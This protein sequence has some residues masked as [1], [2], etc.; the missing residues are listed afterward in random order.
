MTTSAYLLPRRASFEPGATIEID[1]RGRTAAGEVVVRRLGDPIARLAHDGGPTIRLERLPEGRYGVELHDR[2]GIARTAVEVTATPRS[3]LRYGFAVD[4]SPERDAQG[5]SDLVRRLHLTGVLFY[6]WA[7]RHADLLGGGDRYLD[8]LAQPV[9]LST[10]RRL[11]D[12]VHAAG[13]SAIGYA[14]V[15]AVGPEEWSKWKHDA[16]LRADGEPFALGDFLFLVDPASPD[17]LEHFQL[18]LRAATDALG[19]AGFHLD[20]F[21]YPKIARRADGAV[22]RMTESFTRLIRGVRGALPHGHLVFNNVNDFP[23]WTTASAPQDAVYIEPW[24]PTDTLGALAARASRAREVAN[25]KPVVFAAYQQVYDDAPVDAADRA[26]ALTMA[27]LF[28]HGAT[29]LLAGEGDR[30]LVDP[31][32]VRNHVVETSTADLLVRWYDFLVEYDDVLMEPDL[33]DVT[34]SFAGDYNDDCDVAFPDLPT[35]D[36]AVTGGVWRRITAARNRLVVHLINLTG[37]VD[38]NWD[39]ARAPIVPVHGGQLRFR[40]VGGSRPRVRV[41]DPDRPGMVVEPVVSSEGEHA[42]VTLPAVQTWQVVIIDLVENGQ[43]GS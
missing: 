2:E 19:F 29:Q 9:D 8:A 23:T 39:R 11:I 6:D 13:S 42:L 7:Y 10:V 34:A 30:I 15:Y 16:L 1:I 36:E 28:S 21:G 22:V 4:F 31:Y 20:Q 5:L 37:Q 40:Q 38:T 24:S 43:A 33:I 41:V 35:H 25:G 26:A 18:Q 17:W 32:Y 3:R 27:T 12:A 14:A